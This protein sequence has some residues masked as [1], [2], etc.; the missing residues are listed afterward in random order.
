MLSEDL[1]THE[2]HT[3]NTQSQN[4][5]FESHSVKPT[6]LSVVGNGV[7]TVETIIK[8]IFNL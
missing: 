2:T 3:K 6:T 4:N 8:V 5:R 7:A 1:N